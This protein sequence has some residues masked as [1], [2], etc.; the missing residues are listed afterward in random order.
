MPTRRSCELTRNGLDLTSRIFWP[1]RI[2][3]YPPRSMTWKE[4][5]ADDQI[6]AGL[7][8]GGSKH[9]ADLCQ[10]AEKFSSRSA[11]SKRSTIQPAAGVT[12]A[13]LNRK[14]PGVFVSALNDG[15]KSFCTKLERRFA[16]WRSRDLV[17]KLEDARAQMRATSAARGRTLLPP[18]MA[19]VLAQRT[20]CHTLTAVSSI[21]IPICCATGVQMSTSSASVSVVTTRA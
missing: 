5:L 18:C 8:D 11:P 6:T 10:T 15:G 16:R 7:H 19:S 1:I 13:L 14:W 12:R 21:G 3:S 20:C 4:G 9:L 17:M 2:E